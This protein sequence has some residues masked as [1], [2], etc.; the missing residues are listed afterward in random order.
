MSHWLIKCLY[1]LSMLY[2]SHALACPIEGI[3]HGTLGSQMI[4]LQ[5]SKTGY[6]TGIYF[7]DQSGEPLYL[8]YDMETRTWAEQTITGK[9]T[10]KISNVDCQEDTLTATWHS[11][12]GLKNYPIKATHTEKFE[13]KWQ[14]PIIEDKKIYYFKQHP[15]KI[16]RG[17]H[18]K[19]FTVQIVEKFSGSET[20]NTQ[21]KN[22][23]RE[24][25]N[26]H[27]ICFN[28]VW[29][30]QA[31]N[32]G[33]YETY[34]KIIDWNKEYIVIYGG[35][36]QYCGQAHGDGGYGGSIF[37]LNTGKLVKTD[38]WIQTSAITNNFYNEID[39]NKPL[40]KYLTKLYIAQAGEDCLEAIHFY[41]E[42]WATKR[43]LHFYAIAHSYA[44]RACNSEIRV[45]FKIA[46][47]FLTT[48][49]KHAIKP[50]LEK[51]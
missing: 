6:D 7:Y 31:R 19:S 51:P 26:D 13:S 5:I 30:Q 24:A 47:P 27:L 33:H 43:G 10:G 28:A 1:C 18:T 14:I 50:F 11:P 39:V 22:M 34:G 29:N 25:L 15:Y 23:L 32:H 8:K 37:N 3:W 21:A 4:T 35:Y 45:P 12:D 38:R 49:G 41:P 40:G 48:E 46:M 17:E 36:Y 2:V 9:T 20:L 16:I 42:T 44:E